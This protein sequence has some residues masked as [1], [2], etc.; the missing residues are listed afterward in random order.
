[1]AIQVWVFEAGDNPSALDH[2]WLDPSGVG[3]ANYPN[4]FNDDGGFLVR[5]NYD[6]STDRRWVPGDPEPGDPGWSFANFYGVFAKAGFNSSAGQLGYVGVLAPREIYEFSVTLNRIPGTG[7]NGNDGGLPGVPQFG[8]GL[9]GKPGR[10]GGGGGTGGD[11]DEAN[12]P[13]PPPC[14]PIWEKVTKWKKVTDWN[15][16]KGGFGTPGGVG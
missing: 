13:A 4:G 9:G 2:F 14:D 12:P 11:G 6:P 10:G 3:S 8:G 15:P 16:N 7:Q 5:L 1:M